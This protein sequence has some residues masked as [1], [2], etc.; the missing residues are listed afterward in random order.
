MRRGVELI[1]AAG[2]AVGLALTLW[3]CEALSEQKPK[4]A[5][6]SSQSATTPVPSAT[7]T[8][9][10]AASPTESRRKAHGRP[11]RTA[12]VTPNG[13]L[14]GSAPT[15]TLDNDQAERQRA[16]GLLDSANSRLGKVDRAKLSR[17][18]AATYAQA[19]GFA[20]AAQHAL[21]EHDYV[22]ATGLAEKAALL[23]AKVAT[24]ASAAP[25]QTGF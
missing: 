16:Q 22:A 18:A 24:T 4:A 2:I 23:A 5:P 6:S 19:T 25:S 17:D 10:A 20:D 3:G 7:P 13:T 14:N 21:G 8:H 1:A 12:V 11:A 9:E 15:I